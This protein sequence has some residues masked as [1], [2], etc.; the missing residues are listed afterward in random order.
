MSTKV[1]A[2][3]L[4]TRSGD[5]VV[6]EAITSLP[7]EMSDRSN[8]NPAVVVLEAAG[9]IFDK[10]IFQN[11]QWPQAVI[12]NELALIGVNLIVAQA[13]T[14]TQQFVLSAPQP[15]DTVIPATTTQVSTADGTI[16]FSTSAAL[17][18]RAYSAPTGTITLTAGS[19]TVTGSGTTFTTSV[20]VG[21]AISTDKATWYV[22]SAIGSD[23][24]LTLTQSAAST[25]TAVAYYAGAISG[26]APIQATTVGAATNVAAGTLT[27]SGSSIN[28]LASTTN[29]T[30]A[31]GGTDLETTANAIARAPFVFATRDTATGAT[32]FAYYAQQILGPG[33]RAIAQ[34]NTNNTVAQNGYVTYGLLSPAWTT[35]TPVSA[36]ERASV[37]R[38]MTGRVP[39][40]VTLVDVPA[41]IQTYTTQG[42]GASQGTMFAAAVFRKQ[43]YDATTTRV[44]IAQQINTYL[45]PNTYPWGR[46]I[47]P[48]DLGNQMAPAVL[49]QIDHVATINGVIAAGMNYT[50]TANSVT[51]TNGST[52]ATGT[53]SDFAGM[54]ASQSFVLDAVNGAVYLVTNI[55]AGT[56][57]ITP[58]YAG[59][60]VT[61]TN[62]GWFTSKPTTM[63]NW[64]SLPYSALSTTAA[65]P[66]ASIV[67]VG[68]I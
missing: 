35:T 67:V 13:A 21:W 39:S 28:A 14:S 37:T 57:T 2:P 61:F 25:V 43:A 10:D 7:A 26:T 20:Q 64:Y 60:T 42:S 33:G 68:A 46:T 1:P 41:N 6:A 66:A 34:A 27:S 23:T 58:A 29:L 3:V 65:T 53:G 17:T 51:F 47:D 30:A 59:P 31:T 12:Q 11:N 16:T 18:I 52:S 44:V 9:A 15:L 32:D 5:L 56:L 62:I 40:G 19:A 38:D 4:D 54:T 24:T 63:T 36:Q 55:A 45:S 49:P 22:V 50:V 48:D 8:A